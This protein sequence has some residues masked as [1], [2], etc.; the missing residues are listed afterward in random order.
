MSR[1]DWKRPRSSV[2]LGD[3]VG[4]FFGG[5]GFILG[6]PSVWP[7]AAV[8][9]FMLLL[10]FSVTMALGGWG[11]WELSRWIVGETTSAWG[12]AG[13]WALRVVLLLVALLV[14]GLAAIALAQPLS[15]FALEKIAHA[16]ERA[17]TGRAGGEPSFLHALFLGLR[18]AVFTLVIG[19]VV[20]GGLLIVGVLVPPA[21]VVTVP[22]KF[23]VTAWLLAWDFFDYPLGLRGLG[24]RARTSWVFRN[25]G[26]FTVFG[27]A[28]AL[29]L[30]IPCVNLLLLPMG[31]AGAA[32]LVVEGDESRGRLS[33]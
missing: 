9:V 6:T 11:A 12:E 14:A 2:G 5:I 29:V 15:G 23:F 30:L 3:G 10:L 4:A 8:P 16:Q 18:V 24:I 21:V 13:V 17:L 1:S 19:V 28:W 20:L 22:L 33:G 27:L 25:F 26:A 31:V 7:L 32:R